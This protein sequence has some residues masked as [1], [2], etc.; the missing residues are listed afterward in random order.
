MAGATVATRAAASRLAVRLETFMEAF[1]G[2]T[3]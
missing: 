2:E 3:I 1:E